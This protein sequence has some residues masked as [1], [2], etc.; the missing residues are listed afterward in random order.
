[1]SSIEAHVAMLS[2]HS[3]PMGNL[4]GRDTGGMNVYIR[5]LAPAL[6][7]IGFRVDIFTRAHDIK[8]AQVD[9]LPGGARLIHIKAGPVEDMGKLTQYDHLGEFLE[10]LKTFCIEDGIQYDVIHS[11]YWLSGEVGDRLKFRW[12]VPHSIMF[13]TLG[14]VKNSLPIGNKESTLRL[15]TEKRLV[16]S[17][18]SIIVA[19]IREKNDLVKHY[20]SIGDRVSIIPCGVNLQLFSQRD[21]TKARQALN[22]DVDGK[23]V[24]YVGRIEQLKGIDKLICALS[25]LPPEVKLLIIGGDEHSHE[26]EMSL[27]KLVW[28]YGLSKRV[29]F[30]GSVSQH[31]LPVYYSAADVTVNP[32]YYETFNLVSLETMACGTPLVS[33]KVGVATDIIVNGKNGYLVESNAPLELARGIES[34]IQNNLFPN[35]LAIRRSVCKFDWHIIAGLVAKEY[36]TITRQPV[37]A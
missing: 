18:D 10:N 12:G 24:L 27:K 36:K 9:V 11:H 3:C 19:T 17:A 28:L 34:V 21:K 37:S 4:G 25:H 20:N 23:Y 14:A 1:M 5:E 32:S 26:Q 22:L 33:T 30:H 35:A 7:E 2:V 16:N 29:Y 13:H 31:S 15:E 6:A 8:D